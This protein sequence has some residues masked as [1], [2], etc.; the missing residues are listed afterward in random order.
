[1]TYG[2]IL[3]MIKIKGTPVKAINMAIESPAEGFFMVLAIFSAFSFT[4]DLITEPIISQTIPTIIPAALISLHDK[5]CSY[6][7]KSWLN[8]SLFESK[9]PRLCCLDCRSRIDSLCMKH[10][11]RS[12]SFLGDSL[13]TSSWKF[14]PSYSSLPLIRWGDIS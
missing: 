1:M 8:P 2:A 10:G 6:K 11:I 14:F 12:R 9:Q 3:T 13:N 7:R 5:L 4:P